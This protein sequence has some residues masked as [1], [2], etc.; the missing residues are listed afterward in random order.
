MIYGALLL[1]AMAFAA[2]APKEER[3]AA[4]CLSALLLGNWLLCG[5]TYA[6]HP[7]QRWVGITAVDLWSIA[8]AL[9]GAAAVALTCRWWGW[10]IW[11]LTVMQIA[12]HLFRGAMPDAAYTGWLDVLLQAQIACFLVLGGRGVSDRIGDLRRRLRRSASRIPVL[13]RHL[14]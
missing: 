2:H 4:L 14:A 8:D 10:A 7:P 12:L 9:L 3:A 11:S 5:W 1:A 13:A 6:E